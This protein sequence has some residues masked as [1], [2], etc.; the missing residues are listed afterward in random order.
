[1]REETKKKLD[2]MGI[3]LDDLKQRLNQHIGEGR[4]FATPKEYA[5]EIQR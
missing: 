3:N 4:T 2:R 1:M 5:Q